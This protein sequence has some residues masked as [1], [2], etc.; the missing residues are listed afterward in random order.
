MKKQFLLVLF[1][2]VSCSYSQ[3]VTD[4]KAVIVPMNY[5][6]LKTE[7]QYRLNTFTKF[8]LEKAGFVAFYNQEAIPSEYSDRCSLLFV[9]VIQVSGFLTTKLYLTMKDCNGKI[10]FQSDVGKSKEKE[11][12]VAFTEA[13]NDAFKSIY[14]LKYNY[15]GQKTVNPESVSAEPEASKTVSAPAAKVETPVLST[16]KI[17]SKTDTNLLYAQATVN[18]YQLIDS[19]PKVIMKVFHTSNKHC[20]IAVKGYIQGVLLLK[21]N[22]WVFEYYQNEQ[23]WS[24]IITVK[25]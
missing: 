13:L 4:Y 3:S 11:Y 16:P 6:F 21:N 10:I 12:Q 7:N 19:T 15:S 20:Y 17:I 18:G 24:E 5:S 2:F 14:D 22:E 9:D 25:F 1:F 8:N 23:L